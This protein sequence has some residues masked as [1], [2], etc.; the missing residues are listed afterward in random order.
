ML[1]EGSETPSLVVQ[2]VMTVEQAAE[3]KT[4]LQLMTDRI[5]SSPTGAL[6]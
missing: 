5:R 4:D 6:H 3:L 2:A 1:W